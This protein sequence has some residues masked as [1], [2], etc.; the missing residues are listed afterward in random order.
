MDIIGNC[1]FW[2]V[3]ES[4]CNSWTWNSFLK[5]WPLAENFLKSN[6]RSGRNTCVL[7]F[8]NIDVPRPRQNEKEW[9]KLMYYSKTCILFKGLFSLLFIWGV[10]GPIVP[11]FFF[12]ASK[13]WRHI[14]PWLDRQVLFC[15]RS[16]L[17]FWIMIHSPTILRK[18]KVQA[19]FFHLWKQMNN[20]LRNMQSLSTHTIFQMIDWEIKNIITAKR[21]TQHFSKFMPLWLWWNPQSFL[22]FSAF[23]FSFFFQK[24]SYVFGFYYVHNLSP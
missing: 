20:F 8:G 18:I 4:S 24:M 19:S 16:E 3:Y 13:I 1:C 7:I 6:V 10:N 12:F 9:M 5:L 22:Q 2:A 23:G 17:L 11:N 14:L 15:S 21:E